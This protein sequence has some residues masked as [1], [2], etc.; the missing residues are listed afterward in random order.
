MYGSEV[1][2][3]NTGYG[4]GLLHSHVQTY[5]HGSHQQQVTC[6]HHKDANNKWMI[7]KPRTESGNVQPLLHLKQPVLHGDTVRLL[8]VSTGR[9]LHS[10]ALAGP[11]TKSMHEVSGYGNDT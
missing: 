1:T 11:V 5:P 7:V 2:L 10:H 4:G 3:K 9:N 8:H 6:Y